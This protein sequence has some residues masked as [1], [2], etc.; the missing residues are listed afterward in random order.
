M[1]ILEIDVQP[2]SGSGVLKSTTVHLRAQ[3]NK[4]FLLENR[5]VVPGLTACSK[6]LCVKRLCAFFLRELCSS[7]LGAGHS[8]G[9]Q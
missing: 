1:I 3:E 9:L 8:G 6:S 7:I 2:V 5:L 4:H